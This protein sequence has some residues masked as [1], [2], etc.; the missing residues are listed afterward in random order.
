MAWI[1]LKRTSRRNAAEPQLI[2]TI[3]GAGYLF[4]ASL[5]A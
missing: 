3:H 4:I 5:A 2:I 1:P